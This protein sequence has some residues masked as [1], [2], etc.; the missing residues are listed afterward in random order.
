[1]LYQYTIPAARPH[2]I[3]EL[4]QLRL[5]FVGEVEAKRRAFGEM[6]VGRSL[7]A[8]RGADRNADLYM[9]PASYT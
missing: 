6:I 9:L 4:F 3:A 5:L 1:M 2:L 7:F 8:A